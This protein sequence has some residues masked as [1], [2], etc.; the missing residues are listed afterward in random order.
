MER[1][2]EGID[3]EE[4]TQKILE[5]ARAVFLKKNIPEGLIATRVRIGRPPEEILTE[6]EEGDYNL[7]IMGHRGRSAVKDL[8]IGGVSSTV[9]QRCQ[10][11][12][13]A[14]VSSE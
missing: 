9:L 8:I 14:I 12:T 13:V 6:A 7:I 4:E 5:E 2:K 10:N 3:H 1:L 11:P